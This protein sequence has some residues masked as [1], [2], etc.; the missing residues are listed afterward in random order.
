MK[1]AVKT[2][3]NLKDKRHCTFLWFNSSFPSGA[4][5]RLRI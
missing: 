5:K 1:C 4:A 2:A 3:V